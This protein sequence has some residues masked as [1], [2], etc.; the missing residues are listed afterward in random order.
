MSEATST[1]LSK[2]YVAV[3]EGGAG[4]IDLSSRGRILVN[5]SDAAMFLNGLVT[6]DVK[7]LA[8]DSWVPAA[9][10]T[11]QGRLLAAVRIIHREDGFLIDTED[12]TRE[13]VFRLL[14]RFTL[15]GDFHVTDVTSETASISLQG[16]DAVN[17]VRSKFGREAADDLERGNILQTN[18]GF[19][20]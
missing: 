20:V 15:A 18:Q 5:G 3:R 12:A 8:V 4:L 19:D 9:F 2:D 7:N 16:R 11:V 10:A 13:R 6:N 17:I 1:S 14:E